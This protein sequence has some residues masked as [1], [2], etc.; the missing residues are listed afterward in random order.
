MVCLLGRGPLRASGLG[1]W[2]PAWRLMV[3]DQEVALR[4]LPLGTT[5]SDRQSPT[6]SYLFPSANEPGV[7]PLLEAGQTTRSS[8]W[9]SV[10]DR[11]P[12]PQWSGLLPRSL[13]RGKPSSRSIQWRLR[14]GLEKRSTA[15]TTGACLHRNG[16]LLVHVVRHQSAARLVGT[17]KGW[18]VEVR[19]VMA[20]TAVLGRR[21]HQCLMG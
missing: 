11:A 5:T 15:G 21:A 16:S 6:V 8:P 18:R 9:T 13:G 3:E 12:D 17:C 20:P 2:P 1:V 7:H 14:T 19:R 4:N 10:F